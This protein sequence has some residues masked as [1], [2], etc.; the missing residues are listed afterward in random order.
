MDIKSRSVPYNLQ[1]SW[2]LLERMPFTESELKQLHADEKGFEG[3]CYFDQLIA[4]SPASSYLHLKD[5]ILKWNNSTFQVDSCLL[6]PHQAYLFEVKN[7]EGEYYIEGKR[8]FSVT[9]KEIK[10]PLQALQRSEDL[11]RQLLQHLGLYLPVISKVI[12][13]NGE[14]TLF[15]ANKHLSIILPTQINSFVKKLGSA[16]YDETFIEK[17]RQ[18]ARLHDENSFYLKMHIPDYSYDTLKKGISC[19]QCRSLSVDVE[20]RYLICKRCGFKENFEKGILRMAES[21]KLLFP[22][23]PLSVS[24]LLDWCQ[25]NN[26]KR[27][28]IHRILR[29]HYKMTQRSVASYYV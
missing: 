16:V 17:A 19:G 5:L 6:S 2:L 21:F 1:V 8:R 13:V 27:Q 7:Y 28:R 18:L 15:N 29:K 12:F 11:F 23:R 4:Q 20:G 14:F 10:N 9:G 3:E 22:D 26:D 25:F 24:N